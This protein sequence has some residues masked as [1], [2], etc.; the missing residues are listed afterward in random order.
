MRCVQKPLTFLLALVLACGFC[1]LAAAHQSEA[2]HHATIEVSAADY[3]VTKDGSYTSMEEVAVYL[4][5]FGVLPGNFLTKKQAEALGWNSRQGNLKEVAPGCSIGG[6]HFGNY[7]GNIQAPD[8]KS[9]QWTE[10]DIDSDGGYRNGKRIVFSEDGLIF[11]SDDHYNTFTQ[12]VVVE[13][14]PAKPASFGAKEAPA[15]KKEGE[16]TSAEET[17]FYSPDNHKSITQLH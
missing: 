15:V 13:G 8:G 12:V 4:S 7:E 17:A 14:G 3:P 5:T 1:G 9:H 11:Y 2:T 6:D 10:C 16:Y